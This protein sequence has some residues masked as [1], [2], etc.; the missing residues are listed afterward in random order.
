MFSKHLVDFGERQEGVSTTLTAL[1]FYTPRVP[2]NIHRTCAM[3]ICVV[4]STQVQIEPEGLTQISFTS[5]CKQHLA[6]PPFARRRKSRLVMHKN[7][8]ESWRGRVCLY[9]YRIKDCQQVRK[10]NIER[11]MLLSTT[12]S[13]HP[14]W[15]TECL[16]L[17]LSAWSFV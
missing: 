8:A 16:G 5:A 13:G 11:Q 3:F 14:V 15:E 1:A 2:K 4:V 6:L 12:A 10:G 17:Y 9:W 7:V